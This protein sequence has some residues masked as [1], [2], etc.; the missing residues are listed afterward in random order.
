[1]QAWARPVFI[2][3]PNCTKL[4]VIKLHGYTVKVLSIFMDLF[5]GNILCRSYMPFHTASVR[6]TMNK[7]NVCSYNSSPPN[8]N[9]HVCT[10]GVDIRL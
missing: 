2:Y 8:V 3:D 9:K 7:K 4:F 1:V 10:R 5:D 6:A